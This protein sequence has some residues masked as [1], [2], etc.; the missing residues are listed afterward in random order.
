MLSNFINELSV[1]ISS[2]I[3][4]VNPDEARFLQTVKL[5]ENMISGNEGFPGRPDFTEEQRQEL[6][7]LIALRVFATVNF[8]NPKEVYKACLIHTRAFAKDSGNSNTFFH[9]VKSLH[10]SF[11]N[12]AKNLMDDINFIATHIGCTE[13]EDFSW[14]RAEILHGLDYENKK[15]KSQ[16]SNWKKAIKRID[17]EINKLIKEITS[18][19]PGNEY[20][21]GFTDLIRFT[22][23]FH[24]PKNG[25]RNLN[26]LTEDTKAL[27]ALFSAYANPDNFDAAVS[28]L[29]EIL[30]KDVAEEET[31]EQQRPFKKAKPPNNFLPNPADPK[32]VI[33]KEAQR[34]VTL[35][36]AILR[37]LTTKRDEANLETKEHRSAI[38]GKL[39]EKYK[40]WSDLAEIADKDEQDA[41]AKLISSWH[42]AHGEHHT[43][44]FANPAL[45]DLLA[46][47]DEIRRQFTQVAASSVNEEALKQQISQIINGWAGSTANLMHAENLDADDS[48]KLS[49]L[50]KQIADL[51]EKSLEALIARDTAKRDRVTLDGNLQRSKSLVAHLEPITEQISAYTH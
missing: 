45:S 22:V 6:S 49:D 39:G 12:K 5:C 24:G 18:S 46:H 50:M 47:S 10:E 4:Q 40:L 33:E 9:I 44:L 35:G 14:L 38:E 42:Q 20:V 21:Q 28:A 16:I 36:D 8:E 41:R 26:L 11:I 3:H 23:W 1:Q 43:S 51:Q 37:E 48:Q 30:N 25:R 32:V 31:S 19:D 17:P 13:P 34:L 7:E 2:M 15:P 29:K 27:E